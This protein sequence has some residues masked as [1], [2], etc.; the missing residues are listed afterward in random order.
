MASNHNAPTHP[1]SAD[2]AS[3]D[4]LIGGCIEGDITAFEHLASAC[5]PGLLGVS[6]GFL[7]QPEHHEAVCRDT[8]VLAWRNLSEP[9]SNTA[10][11]VWLYGIFASRLYN[12]LLALHGSQQAMRRRVDALEAEHSTTVDSP[13]GPRPALL[14]G[15]RLLALSHQVPSVAPSPLLLAELNERISAEIAQRNAPLTPTGERVYPPLYDPALRY[16]MF[17]SRAAFQIKEGFKRR[18]GRPFEDQWFE[19][20]LNKKAGSAL[21]ESQGL[22]R[23]SIEAHLGGRL[24]LEID[25]NALSR[26]MDFPASF[27]N[28]TQRRKISNQFIWPGDWDLKT[29]A[30]ADTQRQKFIRDLWS[31]RLDLTASDSYNRLLNRVELGGALRMHHHGILL[32]SESRIHAYLERYLLFMEDMSC[33]GYKANL[34]K[35]TLGIAI[36]RHGGMVKVNKG[37]HRLAMAQI[38]GIQRVTVRVRAVH[39]LWWEQHKG[40]EQ[41]KR[42]LENVTAA[43]PHR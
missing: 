43:L 30:L 27:P 5:L 38:L 34:G 37:L 32:D 9:G 15:T 41:G 24:D 23:R 18:L 35:D 29:P 2:S 26:G 20:W 13:T 21:L 16:R 42:A 36:D 12:Q 8:L 31:H 33:F 10:P 4:T 3:L 22:P 19:R 7:E 39:Q 6:A 1:A 40:S 17:R 14:S 11:S 28:R 25:P